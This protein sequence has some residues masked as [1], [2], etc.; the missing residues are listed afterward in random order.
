M[1]EIQRPDGGQEP[2]EQRAGSGRQWP[3]SADHAPKRDAPHTLIATPKAAQQPGYF[4]TTTVQLLSPE[5]ESVTAT[6]GT[7]TPWAEGTTDKG[8][9]V[10]SAQGSAEPLT[11]GCL[12]HDY[13][14]IC[15][16]A[17]VG[18]AEVPALTLSSFAP[19][20]VVRH[21]ARAGHD[22]HVEPVQQL[23]GRVPES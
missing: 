13:A 12:A 2:A 10:F 22:L 9:I 16:N 8:R 23:F 11:N 1:G 4:L 15:W 14:F 7:H 5:F 19:E 21:A 18:R 3:P 6:N 20:K 17:R